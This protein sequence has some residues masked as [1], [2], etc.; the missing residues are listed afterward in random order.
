MRNFTLF[1][2]LTF[3][4]SMLLSA[5]F[6]PPIFSN[7]QLILIEIG[8]QDICYNINRRYL[9]KIITSKPKVK[10]CNIFIAVHQFVL[11]NL[12]STTFC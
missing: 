5:L 4:L 12:Q 10:V 7:T 2:V 1:I 6:F 11:E 8:N 3:L 9:K